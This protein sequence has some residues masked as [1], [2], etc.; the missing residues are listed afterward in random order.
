MKIELKK[1]SKSY[2]K[3]NYVVKDFSLEIKEGEFIVL[4]GPSGCGK[5]TTLRM[6]SGL[7]D[8]SQGELYINKKLVNDVEPKDRDIAMVFQSYALFPYL[9]VYENM[10]FGLKIRKINKEKIKEEVYKA[11][12]VL[13]L[14]D[15]LYKKISHLSGG[16]KQRVALGR[17][18]V[19]KASIFL[20]DEPL[21]NLD[22][23]LRVVM[24]SEIKR[25]HKKLNATSIYVTHDQ[26]EAMTMADRI[27]V[28]KD[29]VIQQIGSPKEV[30]N[31]PEN[32]FVAS[33]IGSPVMN[34]LKAESIDNKLISENGEVILDSF[35][36]EGKFEIG[37]RAE[38][39]KIGGN[40]KLKVKF[41]ELLSSY[42][43]VYGELFSQEFVLKVPTN[44]EL[45][46][47]DIINVS[48]D[49][50]KLHFFSEFDGKR[51][52]I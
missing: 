33:F 44:I 3:L 14:K 1:I 40:L 31:Q 12:E 8:I 37:I 17:A 36:K 35:N 50:Q 5:S 47:N 7:E 6:I 2:S 28:L 41:I 25:I 38:D 48:F 51:I 20:L 9:N 24:R 22:A 18:I 11:A 32:R 13:G 23:K 39:I 42:F 26:V 4:V 16:Q 45:K 49:K 46:E 19:R 43:H 34:F 27:V 29:G 52:D 30:Y 10:A 15:Y 21:S